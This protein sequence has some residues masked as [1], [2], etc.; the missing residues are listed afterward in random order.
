MI[1]TISLKEVMQYFFSGQ[2]ATIEIVTF[3]RQRNKGGEKKVLEDVRLNLKYE[4]TISPADMKFFDIETQN[5]SKPVY[6]PKE[7]LNFV[8]KNGELH[9]V[10]RVLI[11][12]FNNKTVRI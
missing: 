12:K 11:Q 3:S 8:L 10:Y 4:P 1:D 2:S 9:K 7:F 5:K 6:R